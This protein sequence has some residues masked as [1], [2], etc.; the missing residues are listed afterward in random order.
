MGEVGGG[1]AAGLGQGLLGGYASEKQKQFN[2]QLQ[3]QVATA[4]TLMKMASMPTNDPTQPARLLGAA[5]TILQ[6][7]KKARKLNL[8]DLVNGPQGQQAQAAPAAAPNV[9]SGFPM[10]AGAQVPPQSGF[11]M[12]SLPPMPGQAAPQQPQDAGGVFG[13]LNFLTPEQEAARQYQAQ[14]RAALEADKERAAAGGFAP[15]TEGYQRQVAPH[16][17][18]PFAH[19]Q[20]KVMTYPDGTYH[21]VNYNPIAAT[22]TDESGNPVPQGAMLATPG[23]AAPKRMIYAGPNKE[24]LFG[25]QVGTQLYGQDAK[26]LPQGTQAWEASL[27]PTSTTSNDIKFVQQP[28][29]S[30][31]PVPVTQTK[32]TQRGAGIPPPPGSETAPPKKA[33]GGT[34]GGA[35]VG[36]PGAPVGGKIPPEVKKMYDTYNQSQERYEVMTKASENALKGDQQDMLN[37][38]ANHLGMTMGLQKGARMNQSLIEEAQQSDPMIRRILAR[39]GFTYDHDGFLTGVVLT[40]EQIKSMVRLGKDRVDADKAAYERVQKEAKSGYGMG[41]GSR[42]PAPPS[43][44]TPPAQGGTLPPGWH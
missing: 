40:P 31:V 32:T 13:G 24:P 21:T 2:Q 19:Q 14:S 25:F 33:T 6:D 16:A 36:T 37:I 42:V 38:L 9:Q 8:H 41:G 26:P 28:D 23:A 35:R 7:P 22:Y 34:G 44:T 10:G 27:L 43:S 20:A 4:E 1:F 15:G 11:P 29:G 5:V 12:S 18:P 17:L 30:M 39:G 3:G